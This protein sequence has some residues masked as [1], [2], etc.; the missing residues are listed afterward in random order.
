MRAFPSDL[1]LPNSQ[2]SCIL[3]ECT[4]LTWMGYGERGYF[5]FELP[6]QRPLLE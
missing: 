4:Q 5:V 6:N 2:Y 1:S 3:S